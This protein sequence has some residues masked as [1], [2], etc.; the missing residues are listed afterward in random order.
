[1][2]DDNYYQIELP[3]EAVRIIHTGL[4]GRFGEWEYINSDN[5]IWRGIKLANKLSGKKVAVSALVN[6]S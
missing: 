2:E 3:I 4:L 1:M 5:C 6:K